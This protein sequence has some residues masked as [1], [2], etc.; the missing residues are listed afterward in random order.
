MSESIALE[1]DGLGKR[2][3][4]NWAL[5]DCTLELPAAR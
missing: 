5:R 3:G 2:Y 1:A 4:A